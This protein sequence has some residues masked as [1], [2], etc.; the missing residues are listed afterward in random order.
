V[1]QNQLAVRTKLV[2][3]VMGRGWTLIVNK[4][5]SLEFFRPADSALGTLLFGAP[6]GPN[7][8]IRLRFRLTSE[9]DGTRIALMGHLLG[10]D[11]PLSAVALEA[12]LAENLAA[13]RDDLLAAP[14]MLPPEKPGR[15]K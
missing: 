15:R 12:P 6:P 8:R 14:P 13:L 11:G 10:K 5:D 7:Q 1:G 9:G 4:P 3:R 2:P